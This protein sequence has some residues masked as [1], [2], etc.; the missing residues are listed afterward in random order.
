MEVEVVSEHDI[1]G[2]Q[3]FCKMSD[4][5]DEQWYNSTGT[6]SRWFIKRYAAPMEMMRQACGRESTSPNTLWD[7]VAES[8]TRGRLDTYRI[9]PVEGGGTMRAQCALCHMVRDM[10]S[11]VHLDREGV[12]P[13]GTHC[14]ALIQAVHEF[15]RTLSD[16]VLF[17]SADAA[18]DVTRLDRALEVVQEA[19]AKK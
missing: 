8:A 3:R 16:V 18:V 13:V 14:A 9:R 11:A 2:M 17:P 1:R 6:R 19:H 12:Y 4:H 7:Q 15:Y 10:P 5:N